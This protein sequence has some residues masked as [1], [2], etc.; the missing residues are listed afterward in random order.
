MVFASEHFIAGLNHVTPK[1]QTANFLRYSDKYHRI[2]FLIMILEKII[3]TC[4]LILFFM[5]QKVKMNELTLLEHISIIREP[6]QEWKITHKLSEILF[7]AISATIAGSEDWGEISDFGADNIDWLRKYSY[8]EN[9][10]PSYHTIARVFSAMNPKEFQKAFI[11][12]MNDY[13]KRHMATSLP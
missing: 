5:C 2:I 10:I 9:G 11:G 6:R 3:F 13:M 8:F 1:N 7:L 4:D 12:W